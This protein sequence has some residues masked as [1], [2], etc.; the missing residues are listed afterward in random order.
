[1]L[2]LN[3]PGTGKLLPSLTLGAQPGQEEGGAFEAAFGRLQRS[4]VAGGAPGQHSAALAA[5]MDGGAGYPPAHAMMA[6]MDAD[7]VDL[8][9]PR[10]QALFDAPSHAL[11]PP[12]ALATAFLT[13]LTS[14]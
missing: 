3:P 1:M 14:D 5:M 8:L 4:G 13:L 7:R 12:T 2:P 10:W 6:G 11:P 9:K